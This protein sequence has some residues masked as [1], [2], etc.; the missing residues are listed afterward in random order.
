MNKENN[1]RSYNIAKKQSDRR[2][3]LI[4]GNMM[5]WYKRKGSDSEIEERRQS[6]MGGQWNCICGWMNL[7][8]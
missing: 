1:S 8:S 4:G 3:K 6:I 7:H 2:N 5:K